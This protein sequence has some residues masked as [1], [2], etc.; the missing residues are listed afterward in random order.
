MKKMT[1]IVR[2]ATNVA[3]A[4]V[5]TGLRI[6]EMELALQVAQL[7]ARKELAAAKREKATFTRG[8]LS[9]EDAVQKLVTL[10]IDEKE[11]QAKVDALNEAEA[12]LNEDCSED[13]PATK[14]GKK[15]GKTEE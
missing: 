1:N 11:A 4:N 12:F 6:E 5:E 15:G 2:I 3:D 10:I 7:N 9:A 8:N 13:A 14:G